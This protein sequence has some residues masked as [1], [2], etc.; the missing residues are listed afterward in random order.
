MCRYELHLKTWCDLDVVRLANK[1]YVSQ[2]DILGPI[3]Y[4]SDIEN[5]VSF[6]RFTFGDYS[7]EYKIQIF[8]LFVSIPQL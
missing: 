6:E 3:D 7:F 4:L 2:S 5:L 8:I 1:T